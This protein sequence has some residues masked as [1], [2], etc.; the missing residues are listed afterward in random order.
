MTE[1]S[2]DAFWTL[3]DE[4]QDERGGQIL[5]LTY[6]H[7]LPQGRLVRTMTLYHEDVAETVVFVPANDA[8]DAVHGSMRAAH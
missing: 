2:R 5:T 7:R 4:H 3:I 6:E 8:L 1:P